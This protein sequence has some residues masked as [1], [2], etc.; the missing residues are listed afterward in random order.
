MNFLKFL[1]E[2]RIY[3]RTFRLLGTIELNGLNHSESRAN[4]STPWWTSDGP[5]LSPPSASPGSGK[6]GTGPGSAQGAGRVLK[7]CYKVLITADHRLLVADLTSRAVHA[8]ALDIPD[9]VL[10]QQPPQPQH[11]L[12]TIAAAAVVMAGADS[13]LQQMGRPAKLELN[14]HSASNGGE[15]APA[16]GKASGNGEAGAHNPESDAQHQH[17]QQHQEAS[18]INVRRIGCVLTEV[19]VGGW[20]LDPSNGDVY[21]FDLCSKSLDMY[22]LLQS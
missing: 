15:A 21:I 11:G 2:V 12:R 9:T 3:D 4:G 19:V 13:I 20:A 5:A 10:Q 1:F 7:Q 17:Q 18:Q 14:E 16:S 6:S 8:F 22:K